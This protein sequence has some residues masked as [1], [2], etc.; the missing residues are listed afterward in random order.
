M[1]ELIVCL[2]VAMASSIFFGVI[3]NSIKKGYFWH[4]FFLWMI[5][6]IMALSKKIDDTM[7]YVKD[8]YAISNNIAKN[9]K[10]IISYQEQIASHID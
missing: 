1:K 3:S 7:G 10:T 9:S 2:T 6:L 4:G 5:G 8:I